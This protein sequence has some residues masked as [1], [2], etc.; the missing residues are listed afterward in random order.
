MPPEPSPLDGVCLYDMLGVTK[1]AT[2]DDIR[3]A[4]KRQA[5]VLHP[6]KNKSADA[7]LRFQAMQRAYEVLKD[8]AKRNVYDQGGMDRLKKFEEGRDFP[9]FKAL[10]VMVVLAYATMAGVPRHVKCHATERSPRLLKYAGSVMLWLVVAIGIASICA[11]HVLVATKQESVPRCSL[12]Q[13]EGFESSTDIPIGNSSFVRMYGSGGACE[14]AMGIYE[15]SLFC[16]RLHAVNA[17]SLMR[18]PPS[19]ASGGDD[20][21]PVA[22]SFRRFSS[23]RS[24]KRPWYSKYVGHASFTMTDAISIPSLPHACSVLPSSRG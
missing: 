23:K 9:G 7:V 16:S 1:S 12:F 14:K 8:D 19:D 22:Q 10:F 5:L 18:K 11:M 13:E 3:R 20:A 2:L 24:A 21:V 4:Y 15:L 17:N 6:D